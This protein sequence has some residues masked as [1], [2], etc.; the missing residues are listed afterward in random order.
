MTDRMQVELLSDLEVAERTAS[1]PEWILGEGMISREFEFADFAESMAFVNRVAAL[2]EEHDH[3][4]DIH[5]SYN[6]VRLDCTTHK[7]G[8]LSEKDFALAEAVD[9]LI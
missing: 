6:R 8:G 2:A 5:I 7:V 9:G 3:H 1:V 4:P